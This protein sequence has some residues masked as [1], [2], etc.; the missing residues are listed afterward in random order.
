MKTKIFVSMMVIVVS[1]SMVISSTMAWFTSSATSTGNTF[2]SG[3]LKIDVNDSLNNNNSFEILKLDNMAPGADI[4]TKTLVIKNAGTL[5]LGM[6]R[7]FSM[8]GSN[9]LANQ[10]QVVT[11]KVTDWSIT[12]GV[13]LALDYRWDYNKDGILTL[14]ELAT[15]VPDYGWDI[16]GLKSGANQTIEIGF[17][18]LETAPNGVQG[19]SVTL[20]MNVVAT[21]IK[22]AAIAESITQGQLPGLTG[23][24]ATLETRFANHISRQ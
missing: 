5:D 1:L 12:G 15:K 23:A 11:F 10:I 16:L 4:G 24:P 8:S 14:Y 3:T 7:S 19:K 9:D 6:F 17:K 2:S 22:A 18:F 20:N 13:E 21:Q